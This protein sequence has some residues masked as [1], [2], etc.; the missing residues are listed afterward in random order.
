ML[1]LPGIVTEPR[2]VQSKNAPFP[3]DVTPVGMFTVERAV[4]WKNAKSP[5]EETVPGTEI[6]PRRVQWSNAPVRIDP[7]PLWMVTEL[8]E[9]HM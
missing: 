6:E 7:T 3:I 2:E 9:L 8:S 1:T 4:H 5:M